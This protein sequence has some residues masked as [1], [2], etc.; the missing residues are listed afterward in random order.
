MSIRQ[1]LNSLTPFITVPYDRKVRAV[2]DS[3]TGPGTNRV[4]SSILQKHPHP[5][6]FLD[7]AAASLLNK[8]DH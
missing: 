4:P 8:N 2:R 5:H 6:L 7:S 1:I 3:V